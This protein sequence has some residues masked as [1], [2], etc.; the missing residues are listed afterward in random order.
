MV[1][2]RG[3]IYGPP[4]KVDAFII[5]EQLGDENWWAKWEPYVTLQRN[6]GWKI[7]PKEDPL[8]KVI[9]LHLVR[10]HMLAQKQIDSWID[11]SRRAEALFNLHWEY[12]EVN[13]KTLKHRGMAS[14]SNDR[15]LQIKAEIT[16]TLTKGDVAWPFNDLND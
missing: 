12:M 4:A 10:D 1:A 2:Y 15:W 6:H 5:G 7:S 13:E 8:Q 3:I 11:G 14:I 16:D 9:N